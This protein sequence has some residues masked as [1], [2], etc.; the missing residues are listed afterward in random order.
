LG[1]AVRSLKSPGDRRVTY[2]DDDQAGDMSGFV[3]GGDVHANSG[4]PNRAFYLAAE[5]LGGHAWEHAGRIW[6]DAVPHLEAKATFI[7]AAKAT[8]DSAGR[9][10]GNSSRE[11]HAVQA[12][13]QKVGVLRG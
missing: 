1:H 11:Q 12:A 2:G 4:I 8:I 7:Q 13:W 10:F 3:A 9:L 5:A 6:Y